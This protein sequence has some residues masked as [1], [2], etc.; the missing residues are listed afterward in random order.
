MFK[1]WN[2]MWVS[3]SEEIRRVQTIID[4]PKVQNSRESGDSFVTQAA[5]H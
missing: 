2:Y 1:I 5:A 4:A 3:C